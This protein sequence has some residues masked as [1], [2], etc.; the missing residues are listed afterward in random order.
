MIPKINSKLLYVAHGEGPLV[1][2]FQLS[3]SILGRFGQNI[4]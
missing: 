1:L 3:K 4:P 2:D